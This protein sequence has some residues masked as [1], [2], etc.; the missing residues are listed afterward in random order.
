M[1][2]LPAKPSLEHLKAQAKELFAA[3]RTGD[4]AAAARIR[5]ALPSVPPDLALHDAQ[6]AIAR[7]YGF[8][9]WAALR[10]RVLAVPSEAALRALFEPH[11]AAPIPN[12]VL[13]AAAGMGEALPASLALDAPFPFLALRNA[14]LA[15]S[16]V[17]PLDVER[18][19]S[20]A[21][22]RE[23]EAGAG[24]LAV[25]AQRDPAVAEPTAADLHPVGTLTRIVRVVERPEDERAWV[26]LHGLVWVRLET[27][28]DG[29]VR[30]APFEIVDDA[31]AGAEVLRARVK[32]AVGQIP[33]P[34]G[35][36]GRV[37][38]MSAS[39]LADAAMA[40]ALCSVAEKAAYAAELR[41]SARVD[42]ALAFIG[43]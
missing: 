34:A 41:L 5:A 24:L 28:E 13:E 21:A 12:E 16:T 23:A 37:E 33:E 20:L 35:V 27:I 36:L 11:H 42:R 17:A 1:K 8:P 18:P 19:A 6:S 10:E 39:E 40:N 31:P 25:F 22:V 43:G 30:V 7:E 26:V 2:T 29:H 15:V 4:P 3:A 38:R 32:A 14:L 9:S